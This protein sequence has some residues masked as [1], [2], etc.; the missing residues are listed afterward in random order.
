LASAFSQT[1]LPI[2]SRPLFEKVLP[3]YAEDSTRAA[4]RF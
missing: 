4:F 1:D 2:D 3:E